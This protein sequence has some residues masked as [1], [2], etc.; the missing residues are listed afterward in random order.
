MKVFVTGA[1]GFIG[2]YLIPELMHAGHQV[3]GLARSDSAAEALLAKGVE[4]HRGSLEDLDSLRSGASAADAVIHAGFVHDFSRFLEVCE[5]DRKAVEALGTALVGSKRPLLV[6]SGTGM[7]SS[8][9]GEVA[10]EDYFDANHAIPRVASEKACAELVEKG[11]D[12]RVIRLPQVHDTV[13]QGLITYSISVAR[14]KGVAAYA[15]DGLNRWTAVHVSDAVRL[16]RLALE[17]GTAGSRYHAVAEEGIPY[18]QIAEAIGRGLNI[19]TVSLPTEELGSH[20]GSLGLFVGFD[21]PASGALTQKR[22]DWHP[23]GPGLIE[24]LE[25]MDY[26]L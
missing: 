19:P 1:T 2:S 21:L 17:N 20:F 9:P 18:I 14:Q 6:T 7:G 25:K 3:L 11:V 22:L 8:R 13:K 23:T 10:V 15:G 26:S 24:D 16:Y 4:P 12:V 5:I